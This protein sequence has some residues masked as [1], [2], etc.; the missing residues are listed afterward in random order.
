MRYSELTESINDKGIF[1]AVFLA[2]LPGAGKS[3]VA[4]K[5]T[6]GA[7]SPRMVNTDRSYEFLLKKHGQEAT[8][9]AWA[10]LGKQAQTINQEL[11]ANYL[12]GMLP[13]F[14]D[15]T[16]ANPSSALRRTGIADSFGYDTAMIWVNV[17]FETALER[18]QGRERKVDTSFVKRVYETLESNKEMYR[19]RFGSEFIEVDNNDD[20]FDAME[21]KVFN[22]TNR[23]F[24]SPV[25][26]PIGQRAMEQLEASGEKYLV[27]SIYSDEYIKKVIDVWYMT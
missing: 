24:T 23:F 6:D 2:G 16:S 17:S 26:N 18:I 14:I 21:S 5:V 9:A 15:G 8:R 19:G 12:N 22:I 13:M 20:N 10:L 11:L 25:K 3:T 4:Q 1:K 7:V 27:P